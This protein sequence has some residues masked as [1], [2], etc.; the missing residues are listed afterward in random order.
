MESTLLFLNFVLGHGQRKWVNVA[1][2]LH[3]AFKKERGYTRR[4]DAMA[5]FRY[6][7]SAER[8]A[9]QKEEESHMYS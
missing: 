1:L 4:R 2:R 6:F 8:K 5:P 9:M 3:T 7:P